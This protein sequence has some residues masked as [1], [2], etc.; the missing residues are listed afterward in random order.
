MEIILISLA[1][2]LNL[3]IIIVKIK[4]GRYFDTL[5]DASA[6]VTLGSVFGGTL[7][8]MTIAM[9]SG[10]LITI[11]LWFQPLIIPQSSID[12]VVKILKRTSIVLF[13]IA[14]IV[15]IGERLI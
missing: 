15:L 9:I 3:I 10:A 12:K 14:I 2:A 13:I 7:G 6:M 1:T 5:V 8:G 11:Y 4:K